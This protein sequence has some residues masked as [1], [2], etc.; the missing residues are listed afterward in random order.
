MDA[1]MLSQAKAESPAFF[2]PYSKSLLRVAARFCR[3]SKAAVTRANWLT[4]S[5]GEALSI[6]VCPKEVK[7]VRED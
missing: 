3:A 2:S 4:I 5:L 7:E 6:T 1:T